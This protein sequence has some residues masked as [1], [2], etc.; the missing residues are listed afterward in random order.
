M[1]KAKNAIRIRIKG[2][3][4]LEIKEP[5]YIDV[6]I[7]TSKKWSDVKKQVEELCILKHEWNTRLWN[8]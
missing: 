3:E 1:A 5:K 2:D 8:I 6:P 7:D 4:R